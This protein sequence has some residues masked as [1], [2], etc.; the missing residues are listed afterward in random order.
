[1]RNIASLSATETVTKLSANYVPENNTADQPVPLNNAAQ[2][3]D[4]LALV[5]LDSPIS[6]GRKGVFKQIIT[7]NDSSSGISVRRVNCIVYTTND[8]AVNDVTKS[9]NQT[10]SNF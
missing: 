6:A 3:L 5:K 2:L 4:M 10:C 8:V 1:M 9:G 7:V